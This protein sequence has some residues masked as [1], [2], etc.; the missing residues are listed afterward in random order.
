MNKFFNKFLFVSATSLLIS[1]GDT[2]T[3]TTDIG[4]VLAA[5]T[6]SEVSDSIADDS[7]TT[8]LLQEFK[9]Q[10]FS[11]S[12]NCSATDGVVTVSRTFS[13]SQTLELE[14]TKLEISSAVTETGTLSR[15]WD[16]PTETLACSGSKASVNFANDTVVNGLTVT[17]TVDRERSATRTI[18]HKTT[19]ISKTKTNSSTVEGTRTVIWATGSGEASGVVTRLKSITSNIDRTATITKKDETNETFTVNVATK[20]GSPLSV[21]VLRSATSP[22]AATQK[23]IKS[24]VVVSTKT[25]SQKIE[26]SFDDVVYD[27]DGSNPCLPTSGSITVSTFIPETATTASSVYTITFG[28]DTD[29]T[30]AISKDGATA[31]DFAEFDAKGCDLE[32]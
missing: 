27:V 1:C 8:S 10:A 4:N 23:T 9:P 14:T 26:S 16:H 29:S 2:S 7:S 19:G 22:Y 12:G 11:V 6:I 31:E 18:T 20:E 5:D 15:V 24:G 25:G 3:S 28:E 32:K 13:G 17:Q 30:V 21:E